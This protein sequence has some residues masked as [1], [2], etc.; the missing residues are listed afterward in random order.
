M[1]AKFIQEVPR[2]TPVISEPDVLV[3]GGGIAGIAA[4]CAASRAGAKTLLIERYGFLGGMFTATTLGSFAGTHMIID[5][6]R[7]AR[8]VGGLFLELEERL[9]KKDAIFE[10][11][12]HGKI[13]GAPFDT[14]AFKVVVDDMVA[15]HKTD[16]IHHMYAVGVQKDGRRVTAV[17][18][19]SKAGRAAIVP[20]VVIDSTGDGDIAAGAG[21]E[22][23]VSDG[24]SR[25]YGS[26]MFRFANVQSGR[27]RQQ[28]REEIRDCLEKAVADGYPLPRTTIGVHINPIDG[29]AHLNVTKLGDR[30]GKPFDLLDPV[31]L[32]AAEQAGRRQV[33]L[34]EEVFRK[35]VP[36]FE[37]ARVVE[38]GA[39]LGCRESRRVVG[40]KTLTEPDVRGFVKPYDRIACVAHALEKH[41]TGRGTIWDFLPDGEWYGIPYGC[42]VVKGFDNL[43]VA[44]RNLSATQMAHAS[45]RIGGACLA[46]G[47]ATGTAAAMSLA[48]NAVPREVPIERLQSEL[49]RHGTILKPQ[50]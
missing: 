1:A 27:V 3:V 4:A 5:E 30:N 18:V 37:K 25:Q 15:A 39:Q 42:C 21:A 50:V 10:Q 13:L 16:V 49:L 2:R 6:Q 40:E 17:I 8:V 35:Y 7:L 36:G 47:E 26:T 14:T 9:K 12:R 32:T 45:A 48:Q 34:Y 31:Q 11:I 38:I 23:E 28:T 41:G 20:R 24:Q 22:F 19:E 29:I 33:M 43:L 46:M 44:G